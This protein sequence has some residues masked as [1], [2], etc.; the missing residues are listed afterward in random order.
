MTEEETRGGVN[1]SWIKFFATIG[2]CPKNKTLGNLCARRWWKHF[3]I[4][5]KWSQQ[6]YEDSGRR[7]GSIKLT[8]RKLRSKQSSNITAEKIR[9]TSPALDQ[10]CPVSLD[11]SGKSTWYV[12]SIQKLSSQL[13]FLSYEA[14][15]WMKPG[16]KGH[17]KTWNTFPKEVFPKFKDFP[18]DFG[19]TQNTLGFEDELTKSSNRMC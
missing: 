9:Q 3:P 14:P 18:F 4:A 7:M 10:I 5:E 19:L 2:L 17:L 12:W 15:N 8:V 13:W 1:G 16:H 11:I 6:N